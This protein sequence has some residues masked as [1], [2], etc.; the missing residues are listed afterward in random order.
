MSKGELEAD[1][2]V[3]PCRDSSWVP[4]VLSQLFP[5]VNT[6]GWPESERKGVKGMFWNGNLGIVWELPEYICGALTHNI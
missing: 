5:G 3:I 2:R 6:D 4:I 1:K